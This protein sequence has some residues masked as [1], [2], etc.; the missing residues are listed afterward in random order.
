M[1]AYINGRF[2]AEEIA[3]RTVGSLEIIFWDKETIYLIDHS[4][5]V[6]YIFH[7]WFAPRNSYSNWRSFRQALW[8]SKHKQIGWYFEESATWDIPFTTTTR[9]LDWGNKKRNELYVSNEK[10]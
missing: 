6:R 3:V 5:E 10:R 7:R 9:P 8:N 2:R 4:R 1:V